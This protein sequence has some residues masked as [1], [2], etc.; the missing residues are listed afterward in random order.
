MNT[1]LP[2][3]KLL[4]ELSKDYSCQEEHEIKIADC[5]LTFSSYQNCLKFSYSLKSPFPTPKT[6]QVSFKN[7]LQSLQIS[8]C[9]PNLPIV[10]KLN[11]PLELAPRAELKTRF[12]IPVFIRLTAKS[13]SETQSFDLPCRYLRNSWY[14]DFSAGELVFWREAQNI[15][16]NQLQADLEAACELTILNDSDHSLVIKKL[17]LQTEYL[18]LYQKQFNYLTSPMTIRYHGGND[19]S[20]VSVSKLL[21]EGCNHADLITGPKVEYRGHARL[22]SLGRF[23]EFTGLKFLV[24]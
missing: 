9:L 21:P 23:L 2:S 24:E 22:R 11:P 19:P 10:F 4:V 14:G 20:E 18:S 1:E 13:S 7:E 5:D 3:N 8:A 16:M 15:K 12:A 6:S 17:C